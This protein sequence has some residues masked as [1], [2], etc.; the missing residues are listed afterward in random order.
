MVEAGTG[1]SLSIGEY[2]L[3]LQQ[4]PAMLWRA[5]GRAECSFCSESWTS[6]TGSSRLGIGWLE[7][8]HPEDRH[9]YMSAYRAAAARREQFEVRYRLRRYDGVYRWVLDRAAPAWDRAGRFDGYV[10]VCVDVTNQVEEQPTGHTRLRGLLPI[11]AHC[12]S[13]RDDSGRWH[14][15]EEYMS[16]HTDSDLSHGICPECMRKLYPEFEEVQQ[17]VRSGLRARSEGASET[18]DSRTRS[19]ATAAASRMAAA[20]EGI[21]A[22][23]ASS[24]A[25]GAIA[26]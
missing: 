4:V 14:S 15:V 12:K 8:I 2:E 26:G 16:D 23:H 10:G 25:E 21:D 6:F 13:I 9:K 7:P 17:A 22:R 11:C 3:L 19:A 18:G 1:T 5:N 20:F 24:C